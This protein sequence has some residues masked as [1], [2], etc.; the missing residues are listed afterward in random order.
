MYPLPLN[1][2]FRAAKAL[3]HGLL[4]AALLPLA[5]GRETVELTQGWEF[6]RV[7]PGAAPRWQEVSVPHDWSIDLVRSAAEPSAGGGG[8][9]PTGSGRYRLELPAPK[10][11][12]DQKLILDFEGVYRNATVY[13]NGAQKWTTES[14][15]TPFSIDI[16]EEVELGAS[17]LIEV[18]V[19]NSAQP[20]S[21]WY[22][23]SGL[24]RPVSLRVVDPIHIDPREVSVATWYISED[25]MLGTVD[26]SATARNQSA[27]AADIQIDLAIIDPD[28]L[29]IAHYSETGEAPAGK[30]F[31][32]T[33]KLG[34]PHPRLWSPDTPHLYRLVSRSFVDGRLTDRQET[35]FG[36][37]TLKFS[38]SEG[39]QLNGQ[40]FELF[41]G[42]AH[43]DHGPLGAAAY[44]DAEY[45]K[46]RLLKEAGFNAVRTA[47]NLPS[48]AFL[49]A[50]DHYG[51]LVIDEA[52]DGWK[53]KKLKHDY[54]EIFDANWQQDLEAMILR[55]RNHPSV[56]MWSIG[57]EVYERG[58]ES[59]IEIAEKMAATIKAIDKTRPV[60]AGIN[61]LG[62]PEDWPKLD[63]LFSHL[64][65]VGYNYEIDR[66]AADH[67]RLPKRI[68]YASESYLDD[69]FKS[70]KTSVENSYVI[71]DFV[72]SAIDY[73]GEA[74]IGRV[75]PP[76]QE[77]RPHWEGSHFPWHGAA[78]GDI[79]ITGARKPISH[80]RNIVW[81]RG[82][83]LYAAVEPPSTDGKPW[84][85][86]N[87]ASSP[88]LA[89]WTW[90]TVKPGSKLTVEVYSRHP[91]VAIQ[92]N[93]NR[94]GT[95]PTGEKQE[96]KAV[97][98]VPYKK[99]TLSA[100]GLDENGNEV[101]R[102]ELK[103]AAAPQ[104]LSLM[105]EQPLLGKTPN[106]LRFVHL[107]IADQEG[108]WNPAH[109]AP[110]S[111]TLTG[112][113]RILAIGSGAL[114]SNE[115]YGA[116]P[117]STHQGRALVVV[118]ISGDAPVTLSASANGLGSAQINL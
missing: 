45:R 35:S 7:Q 79:D 68:I 1:P 21:R 114:D 74:G 66:H 47:H 109:D 36:I 19:D 60:T 80:Y 69:A 106:S 91:R 56:I 63:R 61:G 93:G 103:T 87:W 76:D 77:A 110:I 8:F 49:D 50:C 112:P 18:H 94:I 15:Y 98:E 57:N 5:T 48:T 90:P 39:F 58:K 4:A 71:G 6:A 20:N 107:E 41:G 44:R 55:D 78:C 22:T 88:R 31:T 46:A 67:E 27:A 64:D 85:K 111:Y 28:G 42:N 95:R 11:W 102:F 54:G 26:I 100:I 30:S 104:T 99:G 113:A 40:S 118:E 13:V 72:W 29:P 34:V 37:R 10:R 73:L 105:A 81:D 9:F 83:T 101:E 53:S 52:F 70:W 38:A 32:V 51:L 89:S 96:F 3:A 75:F 43:H 116:N 14:G 16:T 108:L 25:G 12:I 62:K 23:G 84:N 33:P 86:H 59:G 17:N 97:F 65:V 24:Y 115:R 92:L 2:G 117:R 82:E